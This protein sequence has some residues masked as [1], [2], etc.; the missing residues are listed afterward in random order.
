M[1]RVMQSFGISVTPVHFYFPVPDVNRLRENYWPGGAGEAAVNFDLPG[2]LSRLQ[3][4]NRYSD[5]WTFDGAKQNE[6]EFKLNNGFFETVDAEIAYSIVRQAQPKKVIEVGGGNSTRLLATALRKNAEEGH[7]AEL[8]SIEPYPDP[9]L[10]QGFPG[11]S[12]LIRKPVQEVE[13][14]FFDQL[15]AGD[16]LFLDSSH[17]VSIGSDVVYEML[18]ILPRLKAGV[19]VHFHD[20]FIPA[21]YP[22]KFVLNNLCFWGEQYM[23]QAFL[24]GNRDY[25]VLWSSSMMQLSY[26][27]ILRGVFKRWEGSYEKMPDDAKLFAPSFDGRNVWPCSFWIEKVA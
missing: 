26:P 12:R 8:I 14:A 27:S 5:E 19:I 21:E 10:Q 3:D 7:P 1:F 23:L 20:I 11:M 13:P 16:V 17:V 15:E 25:R 24:C 2:Q 6:Y 22:R 4:W 9:L 18:E